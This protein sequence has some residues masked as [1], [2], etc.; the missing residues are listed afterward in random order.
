[1]ENE[2][3]VYSLI[4]KNLKKTDLLLSNS[5]KVTFFKQKACLSKKLNSI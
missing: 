3:T 5:N 2:S 4:Y 1:M